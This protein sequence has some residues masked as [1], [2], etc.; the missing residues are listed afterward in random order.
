MI[1]K[2]ASCCSELLIH[3]TTCTCLRRRTCCSWAP[4]RRRRMWGARFWIQN[5]R[6]QGRPD[7]TPTHGR[8]SRPCQVQCQGPM[9]PE[10]GGFQPPL[11]P[12]QK[13]PAAKGSRY[14]H[15]CS[16]ICSLDEKFFSLMMGSPARSFLQAIWHCNR[17]ISMGLQKDFCTS[18]PS[19]KKYCTVC[20]HA[21]FIFH[22]CF[23][24]LH[25]HIN[26]T[27]LHLF[28]AKFLAWG[29]DDAAVPRF[30]GN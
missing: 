4:R 22:V 26:H 17:M 10:W 19:F 20:T 15:H 11:A 12:P 1:Y 14:T 8:P 5:P 21:E 23:S 13:L 24:E 25:N 30:Q 6:H 3:A 28:P 27:R 7:L 16:S 29:L 9:H 2:E 18:V